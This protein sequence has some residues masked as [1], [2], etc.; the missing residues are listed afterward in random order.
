MEAEPLDGLDALLRVLLM[1]H[2]LFTHVLQAVMPG[3][4]SAHLPYKAIHSHLSARLNILVANPPEDFDL[5]LF[6]VSIG[7]R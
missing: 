4:T 5:D 6:Q 3:S 1:L 2:I 7:L